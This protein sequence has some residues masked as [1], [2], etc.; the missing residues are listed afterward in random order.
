M[1]ITVDIPSDKQ[2]SS[3]C[4]R[5]S[6]HVIIT[7][8]NIFAMLSFWNMSNVS[9]LDQFNH[10]RVYCTQTLYL[11]GHLIETTLPTFIFSN[12]FGPFSDIYFIH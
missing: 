5:W 7:R 6:Y 3:H 11:P 12:I 1:P 9:S 2:Y 8:H 10:L 4:S